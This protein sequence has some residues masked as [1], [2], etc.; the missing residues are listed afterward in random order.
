FTH[1]PHFA[2]FL[3]LL[4]TKPPS[5]IGARR[6]A[7]PTKFLSIPLLSTMTNTRNTTRNTGTSQNYPQS[8]AAAQIDPAQDQHAMTA[9]E[10]IVQRQDHMEEALVNLQQ[11]TSQI[12]DYLRRLAE[13]RML[14]PPQH[15]RPRERLA[16]QPERGIQILETRNRDQPKARQECRGDCISKGKGKVADLPLVSGTESSSTDRDRGRPSRKATINRDYLEHE[17]KRQSKS[18]FER[19]NRE[20]R[21]NPT[22]LRQHLDQRRSQERSTSHHNDQS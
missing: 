21:Q 20:S 5:I 7:I 8:T 12:N 11:I 9:S 18:V 1:K 6:K 15:E 3:N 19:I 10:N 22:D 16:Q 4:L 14:T 17:Q 13:E 2:I